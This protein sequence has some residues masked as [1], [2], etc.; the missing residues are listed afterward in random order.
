MDQ[1]GMKG[2]SISLFQQVK[3]PLK[4]SGN[5]I[6]FFQMSLGKNIKIPHQSYHIWVLSTKLR[7]RCQS[8]N[9]ISNKFADIKKT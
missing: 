3:N 2:V 7:W 4:V 1:E 5:S 9:E 6:H 8:K